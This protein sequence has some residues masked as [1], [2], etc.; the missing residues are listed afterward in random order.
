[1]CSLKCHIP[2][3]HVLFSILSLMSIIS[4]LPREDLLY[5]V[6]AVGR[7]DFLYRSL[8]QQSCRS[9]QLKTLFCPTTKLCSGCDVLSMM[10]NSFFNIF[11]STT[12][13]IGSRANPST[14]P[15][16]FISLFSLLLS[17][18]LMQLPQQMTAKNIAL[19][20]TD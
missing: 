6:I 12:N 11:S 4:Y 16:F 1:M 10:L 2:Y 17:L 9:L 19:S 3:I 7:N 5:I 18:P 15:A 8:L 14:E 13:S 20:T